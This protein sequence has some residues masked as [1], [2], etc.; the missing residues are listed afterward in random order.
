MKV[1][2]RVLRQAGYAALVE[3]L[4]GDVPQRAYVPVGLVT[5]NMGDPDALA[6]GIPYGVPWEDLAAGL[7]GA[8]ERAADLAVQ[9]HRR[10]IWTSEDF[11]AHLKAVR[12]T[13]KQVYGTSATAQL[14]GPLVRAVRDYDRRKRTWPN[15]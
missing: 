8:V 14:L 5:D 10:G 7:P 11:N 9:L 12:G 2:V 3:W 1:P 13:V 4:V 6:L 15:T